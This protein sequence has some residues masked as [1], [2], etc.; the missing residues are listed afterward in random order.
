MKIAYFVHDLADAAV[1]RRVRMMRCFADVTLLGFRRSDGSVPPLDGIETIELGRTMDARLGQRAV[2]VLCAATNSR[3]WQHRLASSTIFVARQLEMLTLA[4]LA[5]R[6]IAPAAPLV[7]ECLDIHRLMQTRQPIGVALR[8]LE[9]HLLRSCGMLIVSSPA[10]LT[11]H[12]ARYQPTLPSQ[13]LLENKVLAEDVPSGVLDNIV[14]LRAT[15]APAGPPW[16][17]GWF[18]VIRCRRSLRLLAELV[19]RLP[20]AVEV[21]I[22]GRPRRNVIPDFD[23]VVAGTPGLSFLCEYDRHTQLAAIY[24]DVNFTWAADFYE[25]GRN[26]DWLLPNRL[27][28]GTLYGAVPIALNSVETGHWLQQRQCGVRLEDTREQSLDRSLLKFFSGLDAAGYAAARDSLARVPLSDLLD[29]QAACDR[30]GTVLE[31]LPRRYGT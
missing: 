18:G 23:R 12:F 3:R 5:R 11:N 28:E 21:V 10:F 8:M 29:D 19:R 17:I 20:G 22:R 31:A 16:R 24:R 1:H 30:L 25:A 15:G 6:R 2:A 13:L 4:A 26:S 9:R 14:Q 27:Y 7:F